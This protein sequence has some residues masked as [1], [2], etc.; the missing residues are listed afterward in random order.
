MKCNSVTLCNSFFPKRP[1]AHAG[2]DTGKKALQ[3]V[4]PL[5]LPETTT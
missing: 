4:T 1:M 3:S 5:H 2:G